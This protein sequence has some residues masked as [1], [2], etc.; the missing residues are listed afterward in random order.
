MRIA[1]LGL[2]AGAA[3]LALSGC[4]RKPEEAAKPPPPEAPAAEAPAKAVPAPPKTPRRK[5]GLWEQRVSIE[6]VEFVQ[7]TRICMDRAA[8]EKLALGA[9]GPAAACE[10]NMVTRQL[11]GSWRFSSVCDMGSGGTVTTSGVASG[12]FS[13]AYAVRSESTTAGAAVPQ[14]NG[15]RKMTLE[16]KWQ[17]ACPEG[18]APGDMEIPGGGRINVLEMAGGSR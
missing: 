9:Q 4:N 10:K 8:D 15:T 16:A 7:V 3:A 14:M 13:K 11:D 12:D 2:A 5:A 17:G 1:I 18:M 6:G